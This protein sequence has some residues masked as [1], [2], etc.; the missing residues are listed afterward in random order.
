MR[1]LDEAIFGLDMHLIPARGCEPAHYHYDVRFLV[2]AME[3]RFRVS[4]ESFALA[5]V[6]VDRVG[7]FTNHESVLRMARKWQARRG[8]GKLL[9]HGASNHPKPGPGAREIAER[10]KEE[11]ITAARAFPTVAAPEGYPDRSSIAMDVQRIPSAVAAPTQRFDA[12]EDR[13]SHHV[14]RQPLELDVVGEPFK[15]I[16]DGVR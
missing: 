1:A 5:W 7:V 10:A 6:P 12:G 15:A 13:S 4:E 9:R 16:D 3:D 2:Q 11:T 8:G 14:F